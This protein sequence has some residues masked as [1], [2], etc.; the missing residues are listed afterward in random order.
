M[1]RILVLSVLLAITGFEAVEAGK[2]GVPSRRIGGGS[3]F[4]P[5]QNEQTKVRLAPRLFHSGEVSQ[6]LE[7]AYNPE[8]L[9]GL[10][11]LPV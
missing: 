10:V 3:R 4:R 5:D 2:P 11:W 8:T 9:T 1:K 7:Q 6:D